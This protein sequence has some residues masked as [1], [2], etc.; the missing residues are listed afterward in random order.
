MYK[1]GHE[2][3]S[4]LHQLTDDELRAEAR[5]KTPSESWKACADALTSSWEV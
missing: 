1:H 3:E 2:V 4:L 5:Q